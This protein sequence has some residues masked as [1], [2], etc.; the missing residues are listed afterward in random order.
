MRSRDRALR[1]RIAKPR[2]WRQD[3]PDA[4]EATYDPAD[5]SLLLSFD[6]HRVVVNGICGILITRQWTLDNDGDRRR[7]ACILLNPAPRHHPSEA[8]VR[9][10]VRKHPEAPLA[11]QA[12]IDRLCFHPA[13]RVGEGK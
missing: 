11:L 1:P 5:A 6:H 13:P 7:V 9:A 2:Y 4:L 10:V 8:G 3:D 12:V